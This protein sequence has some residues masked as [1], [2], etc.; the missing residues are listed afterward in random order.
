MT[1]VLGINDNV[2][3][4]RALKDIWTCSN[5]GYAVVAYLLHLK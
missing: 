3:N 1:V 4:S 2:N 5:H